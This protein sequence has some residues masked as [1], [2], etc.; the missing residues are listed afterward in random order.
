MYSSQYF[1]DEDCN[2]DYDN[3]HNDWRTMTPHQP[4]ERMH[5]F[6]SMNIKSEKEWQ[7]KDRWQQNEHG[8]RNEHVN[9]TKNENNIQMK[10]KRKEQE[11]KMKF[12]IQMKKKTNKK[13]KT[14]IQMNEHWRARFN[15]YLF[16][17]FPV[18]K[19]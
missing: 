15:K 6:D 10:K 7:P 9:A 5:I 2:D 3:Y 17:F 19:P 8:W 11:K 13:I 18:E 4:N 12:E 1:P 14:E 16:H